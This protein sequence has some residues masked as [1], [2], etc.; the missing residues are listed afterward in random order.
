LPLPDPIL[1][2]KKGG[3]NRLNWRRFPNGSCAR[4]HL[5]RPSF[6]ITGSTDPSLLLGGRTAHGET[7]AVTQVL[8]SWK[9]NYITH[10]I[11]FVKYYFEA[12]TRG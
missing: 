4:S 6:R 11:R 3:K 9:D 1:T 5:H 7:G 2:A 12:R 8:L 10:Y